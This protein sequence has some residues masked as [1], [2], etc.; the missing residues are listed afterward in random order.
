[1]K[2]CNGYCH[3]KNV[4]FIHT[5]YGNFCN[6]CFNKKQELRQN[7]Q[8][9]KISVLKPSNVRPFFKVPKNEELVSNVRHH[10]NLN[11]EKLEKERKY[12]SWWHENYIAYTS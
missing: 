1:M 6:E 10:I 9:E 8:L 5:Q 12:P 2:I 7:K 3:S 11:R 4:P